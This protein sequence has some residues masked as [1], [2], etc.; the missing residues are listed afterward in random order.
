MYEAFLITNSMS[1]GT[2]AYPAVSEKGDNNLS[3]MSFEVRYIDS[4]HRHCRMLSNSL[5][6]FTIY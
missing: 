2:L 5:L 4:S 3:G 1:D 6:T